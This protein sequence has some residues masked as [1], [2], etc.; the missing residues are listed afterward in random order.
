MGND[1]TRK[2]LKI[3]DLP[4]TQDKRNAIDELLHKFKKK[5]GFDDLR[6]TVYAS[7]NGDVS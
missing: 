5:G 1:V 2:K 7:F 3:A 4:L 6:K